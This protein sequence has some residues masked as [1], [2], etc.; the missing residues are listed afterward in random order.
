MTK[1]SARRVQTWSRVLL[2][3]TI[4]VFIVTR[5]IDDRPLTLLG[6]VPIALAAVGAVGFHLSSRALDS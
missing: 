6:L 5:V 2:V 3:L 4:P 1:P